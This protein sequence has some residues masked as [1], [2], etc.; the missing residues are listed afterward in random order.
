M[1]TNNEGMV[2]AQVDNQLE[3]L[4]GQREEAPE[5]SGNKY[6]WADVI[7]ND[8]NVKDVIVHGDEIQ[9]IYELR[10][11]LDLE[12]VGEFLSKKDYSYTRTDKVYQGVNKDVFLDQQ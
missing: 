3:R 11:S 5:R 8:E 12:W 9:V 6:Q 10:P 1:S 2:Q 4:E 7:S